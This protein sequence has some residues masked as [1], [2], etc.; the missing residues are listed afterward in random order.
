MK[1]TAIAW[2]TFWGCGLSLTALLLLV[3]ML[4]LSSQPA[5]AQA[6]L[7]AR[8]SAT[9]ALR[10][11]SLQA[12][13]TIRDAFAQTQV[14]MVFQNE[15]SAQ[16]EADFEY[17]VPD[18]S[19]VTHFAYW[20]KDE[21]VVA[22]VVEKE[23]ALAIYQAITV[24]RRDPALIERISKNKFRARIFP[25]EPNADLKVEMRWVQVLSSDAKGHFYRFPLKPRE[26]GKGTLENLNI[27]VRAVPGAGVSKI[28]NNY[29]LTAKTEN[30]GQ[31]FQLSEKNYR[32]SQDLVVRFERPLRALH[33]SLYAA[34]SGGRDGFFALALTPS[35][36]LKA[37]KLTFNGIATYNVLPARLPNL[38]AHQTFVVV[39][40]YRPTAANKPAGIALSGFGPNTAR[41]SL[42]FSGKREDNNLASKLW[43]AAQIERL[44]PNDK[45]AEKNR[46]RL[47]ELSTRFTLPSSVTS[48]L[49]V[50]KAE[51]ENFK[52]LIA[53]DDLNRI[54][55]QLVQ[56]KKQGKLHTRLAKRLRS[57]FDRACYTLGKKPST[58]LAEFFEEEQQ[59][60]RYALQRKRNDIAYQM[61]D[62]TAVG[63]KQKAQRLQ[64]QIASL[65]RQLGEGARQGIADAHNV[66]M[67]QLAEQWARERLQPKSNQKKLRQFEQRL[68]RLQSQATE[69]AS[70]LQRNASKNIL[71]SSLH[72]SA[73]KIT[74]EIVEG[75]ID[76][77][78][79]RKLQRQAGELGDRVGLDGQAM[80]QANTR[81]LA[82]YRARRI[83][84][85]LVEGQRAYQP[86]Q[87]E[88]QNLQEQLKRLEEIG[89]TPDQLL[90]EAEKQWS[91]N[92]WQQAYRW[93][94]AK[95][96]QKPNPDEAAHWRRMLEDSV[97][98]YNQNQKNQGL[99]YQRS[100]DKL[101]ADAEY[102]QFQSRV[103][104]LHNERA[105]EISLKN[106]DPQKLQAIDD[107]L[108][109]IMSSVMPL[110]RKR[111]SQRSGTMN[112]W[113]MR[114][115]MLAEY[116]KES[117]NPER[118]AEIE[119]KFIN[120]QRDS[121][122][123]R[124]KI[125]DPKLYGQLRV[126]R[127]KARTQQELLAE[128]LQKENATL[129]LEEKKRLTANR[130]QL[131]KREKE[132]AVRM[133]DPLIQVQAP[134]DAQ[135]VVAVFP[136]GEIKQMVFN[137]DS[138]QWEARFDVPTYAVEGAYTVS[139]IVVFK[140]GIRKHL[141][142]RFHVDVTAPGGAGKALL[143]DKGGARLLR[144]EL[145]A[146]EDTARVLALL[147][148][149]Q[150]VELSPSTQMKNRFFALA[151]LTNEGQQALEL[152][153]LS[154]VFILTD[155]AHNRTMV[156]VDMSR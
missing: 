55:P 35:Q 138:Q 153:S 136:G 151:P 62:A 37:P 19:L 114:D 32:P 52:E 133:G 103:S 22:R 53:W 152:K 108:E 129:S 76:S 73:Q 118:T 10:M 156:T 28:V 64:R 89:I 84:S 155:R 72:P 5:N 142:M 26:E 132:L 101:L 2:Q 87:A 12:N 27:R 99:N 66:R 131:A 130:V 78:E 69:D 1:R 148:G 83:A 17:V 9:Q 44:S 11:K 25:I 149:G 47:I 96:G 137:T 29:K 30:E 124:S 111:L 20:F 60:R 43:A 3:S 141:T 92:S 7:D 14:Q 4:L 139:V 105:N 33:A 86:N 80:L 21:K 127:L 150:K 122:F 88:I 51:W 42:R 8:N 36:N 59:E 144:L 115:L 79:V 57:Q 56:L 58:Q 68:S 54:G 34:P 113:G 40:R 31:V 98:I 13:V 154:V 81:E 95:Y 63:N 85:E 23:R 143:I 146:D 116:K 49:A 128:K 39:G 77:E 65:N 41:Q 82:V 46:E 102:S 145:D 70:S 121:Y 71:S 109:K 110:T 50:P 48:W 38:R 126:E 97:N 119:E 16:T 134:Q 61:A 104:Q 6:M 18:G 24:Q 90:Q 125:D 75:R 106:R 120:S 107:E 91:W 135:Q 67:S 94:W 15:L 45:I 140:D 123:T 147:P 112:S 117:P 74:K 93:A 100:V